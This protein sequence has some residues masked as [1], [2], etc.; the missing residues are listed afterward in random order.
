MKKVFITFGLAV[1]AAT[2]T[3]AKEH[4]HDHAL[5]Y[6]VFSDF[7]F[8]KPVDA[9]AISAT[10]TVVAQNFPGW[11]AEVDKLNSSVRDMFGTAMTVAGGTNADKAY[12]LINDKLSKL[13]IQNGQWVMTRNKSYGHVSYVDF[14]QKISG[15]DVVFSKLSFRFTPTGELTR[16]KARTYAQPEPGMLPSISAAMVLSGKAL[17]TGLDDVNVTSKN[18]DD[19]WV[20]FPVPTPT[21]YV[22]RPAYKFDVVGTFVGDEHPAILEGYIDARSG[23]LLYR[24]NHVQETFEVTVQSE[25][26]KGSRLSP[27][28][29]ELQPDM[30]VT[31]GGQN[32]ITDVN[33]SVTVASANAPQNV[34]FTLRGPWARVV[35]GGNTP[36]ATAMLN[37]ATN[38][39]TYQA[40]S[41][42][43]VS[44]LNAFYHVNVIHDF[45]KV[46]MPSFTGMDNELR[47]N[48]DI[49]SS[50]CNAFYN[51]SSINFYAASG[52][53][54]SFAEVGDIVYHEYGHGINRQYYADNGAGFM[55]NGSLNEG[56]ADIWAIGVN[57]DGIVGEGS[58]VS[59]GNIRSYVGAP[60]VYPVDIRGEVHADGEI[61]AG[62]WWDVAVNWGGHVDSM[63]D[64]FTKGFTDL[65]DGPLGTEGEIYHDILISALLDDDDDANLSNGTP[66]FSLIAEAFKRHGIYLMS[67][68]VLNHTELN[69]QA[70]GQPIDVNASLVLS[71]PMFFQDLKLIYRERTG[72]WDTLSM[73][74]TSGLNFSAQIPAK[75]AGTIIDYYFGVYDY[76]NTSVYGLPGGYDA[77]PA[78]AF[79][80]T[81]PFQFGVGISERT[82]QD[83]ESTATDWSTGISADN[84]TSGIWTQV[85]PTAT[86][87]SGSFGSLPVQTGK[88]HTTGSGQCMVTGNGFSVDIQDVDNG[89]TTL[90]SPVIDISGFFD[91]VIEYYRWYSNDRAASS[92]SNIRTDFWQ[93]QINNT[94]SVIWKNV[95]YTYQSD[96]SWRRRIF[97]VSEYWQGSSK[98]Q[99]RFIAQ[100]A[101]NVTLPNNGQNIVEAAVDDFIIYD[102][103]PTSVSGTPANVRAEVF[104]NPA[105]D[106]INVVMPKGMVGDMQLMDITG[107]V[108]SKQGVD[109]KATNYTVDT[110]GVAAGTYMLFIQTDKA[111]Q[112]IKVVVS[113]K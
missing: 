3:Q 107:R 11:G 2:A 69:H 22:L 12:N 106:K 50:S 39:Y 72:Q 62:A 34:T 90:E 38:T 42:T 82:K 76:L 70:A 80:V 9:N 81:I 84:A 98:I 29:M 37:N 110:R 17:N 96:H 28:T 16:I 18:V 111:I 108:I 44:D 5:E 25:V 75:Q 92:P 33:G 66:H 31:I 100:D 7:R 77:T 6:S 109:G 65:P 71:N 112:N 21:G 99:M 24:M 41:G 94:L 105:D 101:V 36:S 27:M 74:N 64:I 54:R 67:D 51:G 13:G 86:F 45:L 43:E 93:V 48:V 32:Y 59:G 1:L 15:R 73:N 55:R 63:I 57:K 61:I 40:T 14:V 49:T 26:Y 104:P 91:P 20:W 97:K 8:L 95:D 30:R 10:H 113:H 47:T 53:C 85:S 19:N 35:N 79:Q 89:R 23:E 103:A 68:A 4:T 88:D 102:G 60:K 52:N 78:M 87:T 56:Y 58:F 83:F 46:W